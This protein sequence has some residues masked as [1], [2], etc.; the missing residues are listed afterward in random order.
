MVKK[1]IWLFLTAAVVVAFVAGGLAVPRIWCADSP[2]VS[3]PLTEHQQ[4]AVQALKS[5]SDGFVAVAQQVTPSVVMVTSEKTVRAAMTPFDFFGNDPFFR[6]F[7]GQPGPQG[8]P[9][10]FKQRSLGS[11]VVVR[12]DG[13]IL[14]NNHVVNGADELTVILPDHRKFAAEVVGTDPRTDRAVLKVD[15]KDLPAMPFGDSDSVRIGEWVM[16]V[17]SPFSENLENTVT[18]GIV[19]AVGRSG[20]NLNDYEYFIQTDAAI[21]PGNSGGALVNLDGELIGINTAIASRGGGSNGIGF[22]IPS[23]L[24]RDVMNDLV[25]KGKVVRGWLGVTIQDLDQD[26]ADAMDLDSPEGVLVNSVVKDG[27]SDKAGLKQGDVIVAFNGKP[28]KSVSQLRLAVAQADPDQEATVTVIRD[29]KK[30]DFRVKLGEFPEEGD[31][32]SGAGGEVHDKGIGLTVEP[33]TPDLAKR[34]N[35]EDSREG[36]VVT[37]VAS[38]SPA[39]DAGIH[40]GDVIVKVNRREVKS[41]QDYR[42]A[43]KKAKSGDPVLFL[44]NRGGHTF[45]VAIRPEKQ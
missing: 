38:G 34:F 14:T 31:L 2:R 42:D 4:Q 28:M 25:S 13:Y 10:T 20:M 18:A 43:L 33:I 30:R 8:S 16:A 17:G 1:S 9:P 11:G 22:A 36:L 7:F 23:N 3:A 15:A 5:F 19:S 44:V 24:A 29:G 12:S 39:E 21:N 35:L 41:L 40:P 37:D 26:L 45:F 27:P 6:R 32:A